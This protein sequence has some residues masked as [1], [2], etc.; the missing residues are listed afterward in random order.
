MSILEAKAGLSALPPSP[1][2]MD[3]LV[4]AG[5]ASRRMGR[6]KGMLSWGGSTVIGTVLDVLRPLFRRTVVVARNAEDIA[7]LEAE[8]VIDGRDEQGP[9]AGLARGL[10]SV[11]GPW[12][13]VAGCDMPFLRPQVIGS[14]AVE[15][16]ESDVLAVESGG[17]AQPLHAFYN[18]R[19]LGTAELLL[20]E[21]DTS[22]KGLLARS[23]VKY[24]DAAWLSSIGRGR[25]SFR[26]LD[27]W[28]DY[29][30]ALGILGKEKAPP[31]MRG[32]G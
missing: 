26:D 23:R 8:V 28:G 16:G 18:V 6:P 17:R 11:D 30:E 31:V 32:H 13:F 10:A 7:R 9:L 25:E 3:A 22:L 27:T 15:L 29:Q 5:G 19:C 20:A 12:C 4:L 21:G 2:E 14:M 1:S 24:L